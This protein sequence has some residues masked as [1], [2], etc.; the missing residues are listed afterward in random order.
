MK[1]LWLKQHY[2]WVIAL[3]CAPY[4]RLC[5]IIKATQKKCLGVGMIE[6]SGGIH[7]VTVAIR[8]AV[9][10]VFL[11]TGIGSILAVLSNR[12]GRAIDRARILNALPAAERLSNQDELDIIVKRTRWLRRA[13][14]LATFAALS[15]C[16]SI[17]ALFLGVELGFNMPHVVMISFITSMFSVIFALLCFL[18]ETI[19]ASREVIVPYKHEAN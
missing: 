5:R 4:L 16:I 11:L 2:F 13:I 14:G 9:A 12:L 7:Q 10:P 6:L 15:V 1:Y 17:A 3:M 8:D 19:L 18:R